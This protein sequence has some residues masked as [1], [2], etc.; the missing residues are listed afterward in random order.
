[1]IIVAASPSVDFTA[2]TYRE[3]ERR[4][5]KEKA[6]HQQFQLAGSLH[7]REALN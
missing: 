2:A 7:I 1:M 3:P 6:N 4:A 5:A